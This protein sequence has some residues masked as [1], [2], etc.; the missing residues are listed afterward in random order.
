MIVHALRRFKADDRVP[1]ALAT[2]LTDP[3]VALHAAG[4]LR[5]VV[6]NAAALPL[7]E[8]AREQTID[9]AAGASLDREIKKAQKR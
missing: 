5:Q 3:S 9:A 1:A 8:A 2:L 4:A 6:G 7:L